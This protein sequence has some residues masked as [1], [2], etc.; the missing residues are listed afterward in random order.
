M[1]PFSGIAMHQIPHRLC[2]FAAFALAG[3]SQ[4]SSVSEKRPAYTYRPFTPVGTL[5]AK[6]L[7]AGRNTPESTLGGYLDA[8]A[9]AEH[10]LRL[11][12][13]DTAARRDYNFAV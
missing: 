5:I 6:T 10:E 12:P 4:Y 8:A 1:K 2:I 9:E 13:L 3:C 11:R 7:E